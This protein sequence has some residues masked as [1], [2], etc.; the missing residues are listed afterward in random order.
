MYIWT[1][2]PGELLAGGV[3]W[4]HSV[5]ETQPADTES[6]RLNL[7]FGTPDAC[8]STSTW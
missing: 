4:A 6:V 3:A 2:D 5:G 8:M 7:S 1:P